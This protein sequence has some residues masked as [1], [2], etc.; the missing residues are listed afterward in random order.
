VHREAR[1]TRGINL[2]RASGAV[3]RTKGFFPPSERVQTMGPKDQKFVQI[4]RRKLVSG[5]PNTFSERSS[6]FLGFPWR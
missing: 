1:P 4:S 2:T 3:Q 5:F 6:D